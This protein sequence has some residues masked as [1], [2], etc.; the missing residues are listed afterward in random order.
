M[1]SEQSTETL[2]KEWN[3]LNPCSCGRWLQSLLQ[4]RR[5]ERGSP[6][7]NPCSCGRWLQSQPRVLIAQ[8]LQLVLI[9]VLVEDGFR[10]HEFAGFNTQIVLILVL[11]ED[12]FRGAAELSAILRGAKS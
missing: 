8:V 5:Q 12:G 7:L 3:C 6:S 2:K 11:V 9:L 10:A 4:D 1:A